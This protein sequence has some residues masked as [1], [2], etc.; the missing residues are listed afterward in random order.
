MSTT[1]WRTQAVLIG[2]R[3]NG[4]PI[5]LIQ[6]GAPE[7]DSTGGDQGASGQQNPLADQGGTPPEGT[8][9]ADQGQVKDVASLPKWAQDELS[10]ARRDAAANRS[11]KT[12][13]ETEAQQAK[14]LVEAVQ[15]ALGQTPD[16]KP[17]PDKLTADL[18][19]AQA[20]QRA[21]AVELQVYRLAG[22][23]DVKANPVALTD[24][25]SFATKVSDLDPNAKDFGD[26]VKAAMLAAMTE[27]PLLKS[28]PQAGAAGA[29]GTDMNGNTGKNQKASSLE[30]AITNRLVADAA[31]ARKTT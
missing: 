22:L 19:A 6:G 28:A 30:E 14:A 24:S 11:G 12:A 1:D 3:R 20:A 17:D 25:R 21:T 26:K 16:G 7:G 18:A 13:A 29:S 23:D 2:T 27:N 4:Q 5:Y 15:K 10:T 31:G 8:P 9:P